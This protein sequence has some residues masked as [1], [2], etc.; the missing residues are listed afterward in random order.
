MPHAKAAPPT[1]LAPHETWYHGSPERLAVLRVGST[2]TPVVALAK[3]FA[4]KPSNA[5]IQLRDNTETGERCVVISHDGNRAGY[6]YRVMV[7]DPAGDLEP[8]PQSTAAAG[9]EMLT[10]RELPVTLI[11]EL[12][13]R[14]EYRFDERRAGHNLCED[15][16]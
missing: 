5:S 4:H 16:C 7:A 14:R 13:L 3:A 10:R 8:H 11:E 6:L 9:E 1:T 2:V 15:P 12:P